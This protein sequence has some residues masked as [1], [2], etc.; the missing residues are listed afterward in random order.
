MK[1]GVKV[2]VFIIAAIVLIL[3]ILQ[4]F[5][6]TRNILTLFTVQNNPKGETEEVE[7]FISSILN[8]ATEIVKTDNQY[9]DFMQNSKYDSVQ[10]VIGDIP[11]YIKYDLIEDKFVETGKMQTDFVMKISKRKFNNIIAL[12][13]V[14][15]YE[16]A[17]NYFV[18][19]VPKKVKT[20]FLNQCMNTGW[21]KNL[22]S[23]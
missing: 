4:L 20:S 1:K 15:Y 12:Y 2:L 13:N 22:I 11:H 6:G 7:S 5:P 18:E 16:D 8:S 10:L 23:S 9:R 3:L 14:G 21:C 17:A 19:G